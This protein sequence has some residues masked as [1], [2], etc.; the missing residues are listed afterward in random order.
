MNDPMDALSG[1]AARNPTNKITKRGEMNFG[2][3]L[4]GDVSYI[5]DF[6]EKLLYK[7]KLRM[8]IFP[9]ATLFPLPFAHGPLESGI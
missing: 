2:V 6:F 9:A 1:E 7:L 4:A 8:E 5:A 3:F